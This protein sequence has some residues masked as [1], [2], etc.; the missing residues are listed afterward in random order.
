MVFSKPPD[1]LAGPYEDIPVHKECTLMDYEVRL[2][3]QT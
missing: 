1:A 2:C 3:F